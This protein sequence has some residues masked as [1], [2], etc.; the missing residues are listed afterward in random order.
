[1][2]AGPQELEVFARDSLLRGLDKQS[3][4]RAMIEGA[5]HRPPV[6]RATRGRTGEIGRAAHTGQM[7][8]C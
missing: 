4:R 6:L 3:I 5:R 7:I 2:A 1:M 8:V